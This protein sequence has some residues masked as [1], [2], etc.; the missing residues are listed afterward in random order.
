[1]QAFAESG[2]G[3]CAWHTAWLGVLFVVAAI[4]HRNAVSAML[5]SRDAM[6]HAL[7]SGLGKQM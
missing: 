4:E 7:T 5:S 6:S 2:F 3:G 1:L